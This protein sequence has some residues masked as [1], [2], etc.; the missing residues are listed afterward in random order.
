MEDVMDMS[1]WDTWVG[2]DQAGS[3]NVHLRAEVARDVFLD[4]VGERLGLNKRGEVAIVATTVLQSLLG[5]LSFP[6]AARLESALPPALRRR[7]RHDYPVRGTHF[8]SPERFVVEL[9][10]RAGTDIPTAR[11]WIQTVCAT[12]AR[13]LPISVIRDVTADIP[14]LVR[15]FFP[16]GETLAP[17]PETGV[18][19]ISIPPPMGSATERP[20]PSYLAFSG[21]P[22]PW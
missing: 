8:Q 20:R 1:V 3:R 17:A 15:A 22:Q 7:L 19:R 21:Q 12:L 5:S 6:A 2:N 11:S 14:G 9:A 4:E 16:Y 13:M 10:D 18:H